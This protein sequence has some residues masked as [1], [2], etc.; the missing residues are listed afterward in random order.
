MSIL[1]PARLRALALLPLTLLGVAC[2][3]RVA[4]PAD[5]PSASGARALDASAVERIPNAVRYR[6]RGAKPSTGRSGSAAL[7]SFAVIG[8]DGITRLEVHSASASAPGTPAGTLAK[9]QVKRFG[10]D[11][12]LLATANHKVGQSS[13]VFVLTGLVR[14]SRVQVQANIRDIDR[15]RTDVVTVI[16]TVRLRPDLAV[17]NLV[18]PTELVAGVPTNITAVVR[19]LNGD[20]GV[21]TDCVLRV[22]G[23]EADRARRIWVDAGD[24]VG[25][26]LTH[27]FATGGHHAVEVRVE[28]SVPS[29][30]DA[31]NDAASGSTHVTVEVDDAFAWQA[32]VSDYVATRQWMHRELTQNTVTGESYDWTLTGRDSVRVHTAA[33]SGML[34]QA[35][36]F[37]IGRLELAQ[38]SGGSDAHAATVESRGYDVE[39][40]DGTRCANMQF[41]AG[42]SAVLCSRP[43]I[44]ATSLSYQRTGTATTY[45]GQYFA[46]VWH[47]VA[48]GFDSYTVSFPIENAS[49]SGAMLGGLVADYAFSVRLT[50]GDWRFIQHAPVPIVVAGPTV[51]DTPN[52]CFPDVVSG[53]SFRR[54]CMQS[55]VAEHLAS[56]FASGASMLP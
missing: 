19:E 51:A 39:M 1:R 13:A 22:N 12:S 29:D 26:A 52:T 35:L 4:A 47:R 23:I 10:L 33:F 18:L 55:T 56:G 40:A 25:C 34:P 37:P 38:R 36:S 43:S 6:D 21:T 46:L 41:A 11:H 45:Q 32:S 54:F 44:G 17:S 31:S 50:Q 16:D 27:T 48:A 15:A 53:D 5:A 8:R 24:A 42:A 49:A 20:F 30:D 14:G 28:G 3:D 7:S 2:A 9:V